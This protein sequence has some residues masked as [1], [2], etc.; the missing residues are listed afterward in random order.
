MSRRVA[1]LRQQPDTLVVWGAQAEAKWTGSVVAW[2]MCTF[3]GAAGGARGSDVEARAAQWL[4]QVA[5][6]A[7][8][9]RRQRHSGRRQGRRANVATALLLRAT[10]AAVTRR[11]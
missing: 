9:R 4:E 7:K 11:V 3:N 5:N 10:R 1:L 8:V 2:S 6:C